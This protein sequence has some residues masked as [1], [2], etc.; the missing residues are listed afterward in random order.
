MNRFILTRT[1]VIQSDFDFSR[2]VSKAKFTSSA[3]YSASLG[4]PKDPEKKRKVRCMVQFDMGGK[5]EPVSISVKTLSEFDI[6][7]LDCIETLSGDV[8]RSCLKIALDEI[9]KKVSTLIYEHIGQKVN[10]PIPSPDDE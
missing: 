6:I 9:S 3:N 8:E 1:S 4:L 2:L 5:T 7:E 10:I